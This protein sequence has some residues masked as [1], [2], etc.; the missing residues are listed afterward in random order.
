MKRLHLFALLCCVFFLLAPDSIEAKMLKRL[1]I[2]KSGNAFWDM[3][4]EKKK[5]SLT[6]DD[7]PHPV[8]TEAILDV[9]EENGVKAT[10]FCIGSRLDKYPSIAKRIIQ[11][12][13]EIGS[14]TMN[15]V[16]FDH[17]DK[18]EIKN[19]LDSASAEIDALQPNQHKLFRP[20]GGSL[21]ETAFQ[22]LL[23]EGYQIVMWSWNQD[24]KDWAKPGKT[25]I[26]NH[27]VSNAKGGDIILL[28]DGGGNRRQ[29]VKAIKEIIPQL[30]NK[31]YEFVK[32]SDLLEKSFNPVHIQ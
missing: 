19:E 18:E 28:H 12:G 13:H 30:K 29:T 20:P 10:F 6:F 26:V 32:V 22:T 8:Y 27:V 15:H 24:P 2:E 11:Q 21:N 3:R 31:G 4:S 16:F 1:D 5:L 7:G 25:K 17:L 9:L 14:H 23:E